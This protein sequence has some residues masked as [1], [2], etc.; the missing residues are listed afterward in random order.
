M[1]ERSEEQKT[2]ERIIE[3]MR[4]RVETE[5]FKHCPRF[6]M[7]AY[8]HMLLNAADKHLKEQRGKV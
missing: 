4:A 8:G 1:N 3:D 2:V 6:F 5:D 7:R